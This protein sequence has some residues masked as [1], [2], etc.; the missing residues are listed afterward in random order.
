M[1][2]LLW[3]VF[4]GSR[5]G[6]TR[7]RIIMSLLEHPMNTNQLAKALGMD[8]KTIQYDLRVLQQH[9]YVITGEGYGKLWSPSKNLLAAEPAF[10]SI[11]AKLKLGKQ[12]NTSSEE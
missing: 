10:W 8:Y 4:A 1:D 3:Y 6:A 7:S 11:V 5:G 12:A 9:R 2:R